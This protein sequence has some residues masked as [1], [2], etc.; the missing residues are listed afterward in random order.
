MNSNNTFVIEGQRI[1]K[2]YTLKSMYDNNCVEAILDDNTIV[3]IP[4]STINQML[5][6]YNFEATK[7]RK[8]IYLNTA[9]PLDD[10]NQ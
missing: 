5:N 2:I 4:M 6:D 8:Y 3:R 7:N 10:N 9:I 1:V